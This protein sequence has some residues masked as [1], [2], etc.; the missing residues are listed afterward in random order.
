MVWC[1]IE[2]EEFLQN[3]Y[4]RLKTEWTQVAAREGSDWF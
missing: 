1:F 2:D 4:L 3:E